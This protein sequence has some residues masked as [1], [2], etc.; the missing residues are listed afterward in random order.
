MR[1]GLGLR[2]YP[3]A[4]TY[5]SSVK[6]SCLLRQVL[7]V[8]MSPVIITGEVFKN[9][10]ELPQEIFKDLI[11]AGGVEK[12]K[13]VIQENWKQVPTDIIA[14][15]SLT[16]NNDGRLSGAKWYVTGQLPKDINLKLSQLNSEAEDDV[17]IC[18][19][20]MDLSMFTFYNKRR[21]VSGWIDSD[22]LDIT[23]FRKAKSK[24]QQVQ[25][26]QFETL[27]MRGFCVRLC[28]MPTS[29]TTANMTLALHPMSKDELKAKAPDNYY[30]NCCP[31]VALPI[32]ENNAKYLTVKLGIEEPV[33]AKIGMG[34]LPVIEDMRTEEEVANI[35]PSS[36][37][38]RKAVH[39]FLRSV[40]SLN[41]KSAK[42][43]MEA[44][45]DMTTEVSRSYEP[46]YIWPE[47][48]TEESDEPVDE[49]GE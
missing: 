8:N 21:N 46:D 30:K 36:L 14:V 48:V 18:I 19:R 42:K 40:K 37:E 7:C 44:M 9:R 5:L 11:A 4:C 26:D 34:I 15:P 10:K 6:G 45:E 12:V 16:V 25:A 1:T 47:A 13:Q 32:G 3:I 41:N 24:K 27:G 31:Q 49:L 28:V 17:Y 39:N 33:H 23:L 20:N 38:I 43:V 29:T 2:V 35:S 22:E